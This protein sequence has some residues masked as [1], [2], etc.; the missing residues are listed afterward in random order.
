MASHSGVKAIIAALLGNLGIAVTKL[1]AFAL[2]GSSSMLAESVHSIA[3]TGNQLLLLL[4]GRR[5]RREPDPAHPFGYG[6]D[7]YFYAFVV[8]LVLF[9]LGG[10]F[11][12]FEAWEKFTHPEPIEAWAWVPLAVLGVSVALESF[13]LRTAVHEARPARGSKTWWQF[14]R[15]AKA[16]EL[17]VVLL[18][19][20]A[21][22]TGLVLALGGVSA[23][24]ATGDGRWD[25]VG[26]AAIGLLLIAVAVVLARETKSLLL[27]EA[28]ADDDVAAIRAALPGQGIASVIHLRT[29]HL[30]PE[31]VLVAAKVETDPALSSANLAAA[32][33]A[34]ETRARAAVSSDLVIYLEPDLRREPE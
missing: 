28:A 25:A 33:D 1:I 34:A 31:E 32:I 27:G 23:T 29:V 8:A 11:A 4:G 2:S 22:L 21:A 17:P 3:D 14:I 5:A 7:R 18:E 15:T 30:G 16:P 9:S 20:T 19:D 10:C 24:L 6:R 26:S 12:L 13:S